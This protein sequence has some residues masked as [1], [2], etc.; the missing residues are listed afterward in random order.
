MAWRQ[1]RIVCCIVCL[2]L[3]LVYH[4]HDISTRYGVLQVDYSAQFS[5]N[6]AQFSSNAANNGN[7]N[8]TSSLLREAVLLVA[9]HSS[10]GIQALDTTPS[11]IATVGNTD[12]RLES[13]QE[14]S[15]SSKRNATII[16]KHGANNHSSRDD[17]PNFDD[18]S[19]S[20]STRGTIS[21]RNN[22]TIPTNK[23]QSTTPSIA[24]NTTSADN[25]P[26]NN[27]S[28]K[29]P[30]SIV[31]QLSG[32]MGNNLHKIAF[33]Q[34]LQ[35][36]LFQRYQM[37]TQL[38]F[39]RQERGGKWVFA[40]K[41]I[42]QC[43]PNLR[44]F[45]FELGNSDEFDERRRQQA[46][47]L[48]DREAFQLLELPN[49]INASLVDKGLE[50]LHRLVANQTTD[51]T[52]ME[53]PPNANISLPFIYSQAFVNYSLIDQFYND[54]RELFA[55]DELA[56]CNLLPDADESVFVSLRFLKT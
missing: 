52:T 24:K 1:R 30:I 14:D 31:V 8:A 41:D 47:W 34:A 35:N 50:Y 45:D 3:S 39:R 4:N 54:F 5:S 44:D 17:T 56:C 37:D 42:Q 13:S 33:G 49:G 15:F 27:R 32:E 9:N 19:S 12:E 23:V 28:K 53:L 11:P 36:L 51:R 26:L 55:F 18:T 20:S 29:L 38:V 10:G 22:L 2:I 16:P 25:M 40:R 6:A 7:H 43:F 46:N 21:T 48:K